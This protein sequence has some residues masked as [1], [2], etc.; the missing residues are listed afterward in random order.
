MNADDGKALV[1]V[2]AA[3]FDEFVV[4][5]E[6]L[7]LYAAALVDVDVNVGAAAVSAWVL[8]ER[9]HP[10]IAELRG[11]CEVVTGK[12]PPDLDK[13]WEEVRTAASSGQAP[14]VWSHPAVKLAVAAVGFDNLRRSDNPVADRAHFASAYS[15]SRKRTADPGSAA[16][17]R[18]IASG[19]RELMAIEPP[20]EQKKLGT[21]KGRQR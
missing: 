18:S 13:A 8:R 21:G 16:V 11:A 19:V 2:L 12:A 15:A 1:A 5:P 9:K 6:R 20:V 4:T 7:E 14:I 17:S 3:A 10:T